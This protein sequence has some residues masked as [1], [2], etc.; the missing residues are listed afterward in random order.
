LADLRC[1]ERR[2]RSLHNW[3]VAQALAETRQAARTPR[4][5]VL[6]IRRA[7]FHTA[8]RLARHAGDGNG[9]YTVKEPA[10]LVDACGNVRIICP[11]ETYVV[12][13]A[14]TERD[15]A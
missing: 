9:L 11:E 6:L 5:L 10:A 13:L 2:H 1:A 7:A 14:R 4:G 3:H 12:L 8:W 15:A